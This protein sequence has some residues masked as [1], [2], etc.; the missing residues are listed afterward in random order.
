MVIDMCTVSDLVVMIVEPDK[1]ELE[2]S[3]ASLERLGIK[4]LLCVRKYTDA[5]QAVSE[6]KDI[7]IVIADFAIEAGKALGLLLCESMK[8]KHPGILFILVS[9]E[10]CCSVV[11]DSLRTG[12]ADILDKSRDGEI[13]DLM[14]KW[15]NLAMQKNITKEIL[16]GKS[17][18][19]QTIG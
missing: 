9:K 8:K 3:C 11:L 13:E 10:Y 15:I 5:I 4:K 16:Y 18:P 12:A 19:D 17:R 1:K 2:R 6:N 7:D 14:G